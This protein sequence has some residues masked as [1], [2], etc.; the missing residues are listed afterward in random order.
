MEEEIKDVK[1]PITIPLDWKLIALWILVIIILG[2]L[3][4]YIYQRY[5]KKKKVESS[6]PVIYIPP[7][8][9]A[10]NSLNELEQKRLWQK[11][12]IKEYHTSITEIIRR[13]FEEQFFLPALELP[14]SEVMQHLRKKKDAQNIL[15]IT[16]NFFNN[17]DLVKF[18][19]YQPMNVVNEKMMKQAIDIIKKTMPPAETSL[20]PEITN[21]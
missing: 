17:A 20:K 16:E 13:Y 14:S 7:Y 19:K 10:L 12:A 18:A 21:V 9:K 1:E 8:E 4:S 5:F 6:L 11:G 2:I 15:E 3:G